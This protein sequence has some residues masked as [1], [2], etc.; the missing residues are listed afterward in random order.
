MLKSLARYSYVDEVLAEYVP[1][2]AHGLF[3]SW[4]KEELAELIQRSLLPVS[5]CN[6]NDCAGVPNETFAK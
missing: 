3:D 2:S 4:Q 1:D 6:L 5:R